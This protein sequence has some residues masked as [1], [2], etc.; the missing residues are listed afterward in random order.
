MA[1]GIS[2]GRLDV[3]TTMNISVIMLLCIAAFCAGLSV[4]AAWVGRKTS[5]LPA[6]TANHRDDEP[7]PLWFE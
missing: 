2:V 5:D 3:R 6:P 1:P 4:R 7:Y